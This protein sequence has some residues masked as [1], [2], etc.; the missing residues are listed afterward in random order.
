MQISFFFARTFSAFL[1]SLS[2][3]TSLVAKVISETVSR[4]RDRHILHSEIKKMVALFSKGILYQEY[5]F[6]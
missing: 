2:R 5:I 1:R 4:Y 6:F 3:Q